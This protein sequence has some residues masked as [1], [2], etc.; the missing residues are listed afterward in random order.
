M[1]ALPFTDRLERAIERV[2]N[3]RKRA[4]TIAPATWEQRLREASEMIASG[5]WGEAKPVHFV[6]LYAMG[7]LKCYGVEAHEL[8][9]RAR[10]NASALAGR[11]LRDFFQDD[12]ARLYAFVVWV[13]KREREREAWRRANGRETRRISWQLQ[14]GRHLLADYEMHLRSAKR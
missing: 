9:S 1:S 12:R 11:M 4:K 14:F 10:M 8:T 2:E 6:A 7:H 5:D 13:W 3:P